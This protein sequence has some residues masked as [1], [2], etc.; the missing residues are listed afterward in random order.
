[1][2]SI[3]TVPNTPYKNGDVWECENNIYWVGL[4]KIQTVKLVIIDKITKNVVFQVDYD[5]RFS[6]ENMRW[7]EDS[8]YEA[9]ILAINEYEGGLE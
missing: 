1:M 9:M 2:T 7:L 8:V 4:V 3:T 6:V 5:S